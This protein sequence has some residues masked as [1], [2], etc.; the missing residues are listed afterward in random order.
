M[1]NFFLIFRHYFFRMIREP[2]ALL[3]FILLPL[4][5]VFMNNMI[6]FALVDVADDI[7]NGYSMSA[8]FVAVA[9]A[10]LFQFIGGSL[11]MDAFY[12]ELRASLRWRLLAAPVSMNKYM[13]A[14][15]LACIIYSVLMGVLVFAIS[16]IF[17][18]AYLHNPLVV[19][20]V[21]VTTSTFSQLLGML[22]FFLCKRKNA[23]EAIIGVF[24]GTMGVG[25][26]FLGINFGR[27]ADFIFNNITPLAVSLRAVTFSGFANAD[28]NA[29]M[30]IV[31]TNWGIL[32]ALTVVLAVAVF[33]LGRRQT[34]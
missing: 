29:D 11:V 27:A 34:L 9:I 13:M 32:I 5:L 14:N 25:M 3:I 20:G 16:A 22:L 4:S 33:T 15:L 1:S 18:N 17:F 26:G 24:A 21:L 6:N 19:L 7:V 10:L 30:N 28:M 12:T 8:T 23:A 31:I 2:I